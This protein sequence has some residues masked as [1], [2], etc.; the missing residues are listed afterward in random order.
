MPAT[1]SATLPHRLAALLPLLLPI[2]ASAGAISDETI[3]T[4]DGAVHLVHPQE[5]PKGLVLYL[6]AAHDWDSAASATA[7]E[8]ADQ[9]YLVAGLDWSARADARPPS[10]CWDLGAELARLGQSLATEYQLPP[11]TAP[12]LLGEGD[13]AALVYG[14]LLQSPPQRFHAAVSRGFC[15]RWPVTPQPCRSGSLTDA[16]LVGDQLQPATQVPNA[17]FV[18]DEPGATPCPAGPTTAF[19]DHIANAR[20][21]SSA[22]V[23]NDAH[24]SPLAALFQWLDPRIPDQ[25]GVVSAEADVAGLP[26]VEVRAD[27]EDPTTFAVMLSGDGGWAAIDRGVSA[28]LAAKGISAVGWDSLG[29]FWKQRQPAEAAQDLARVVRHYLTAWHKE[30]VLLIGYSFG[31]EVL[32]FMANGLP[33][34]LRERVGLVALLGLGHTAMFEFHLGDWLGSERGADAMPVLPQMRQL[35]WTHGLCV[36]GADEDDTLCPELKGSPVSVVEFPGDH[37]FDDDYQGVA[38]AILGQLR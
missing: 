13:G 38:D 12:L 24:L 37:H 31:A 28:R 33:E 22:P 4:A 5:A 32:P 11:G 36:Y 14:A 17:W 2:G 16:Q 8:V 20:L 25:V 6:P 3:T 35:T 18:F 26:L 7:H 29:Y 1:R 9:G 34:D 27:H 21:A 23:P 10:A 30:R 15:P 19:I